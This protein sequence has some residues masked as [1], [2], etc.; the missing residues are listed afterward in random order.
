MKHD[1]Q[2]ERQNPYRSEPLVAEM[3]EDPIVHLVMARDQVRSE[4]VSRLMGDM[5][6]RLNRNEKKAA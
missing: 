2:S 4:D 6:A 1:I 3:L 5:A